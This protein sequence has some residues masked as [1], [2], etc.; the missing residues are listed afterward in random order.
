[1]AINIHWFLLF[2]MVAGAMLV[3]VP[4]ITRVGGAAVVA[5][6]PSSGHVCRHFLFPNW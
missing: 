3:V 2:M 4:Y 6:D 5:F 1:M